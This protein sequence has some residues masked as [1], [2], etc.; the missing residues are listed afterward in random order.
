MHPAGT[1]RVAR[2][3][4]METGAMLFENAEGSGAAAVNSAGPNA[5]LCMPDREKS[6][7]A[8]CPPIRP[9]GYEHVQHKHIVRKILLENTAQFASRKGTAGAIAGFSCWALGYLDRRYR[10]VGCLLHPARHQG[11]DERNRTGFGEKCRRETCPEAGAFLEL[12]PVVQQKWL[13]LAAGLDAFSYSSRKMNPMWTLLGWGSGLLELIAQHEPDTAFSAGKFFKDY[14]FFTTGLNSR[15]HAYLVLSL[16]LRESPDLL[17][18]PR[19]Q[20]RFRTFSSR[21]ARSLRVTSS[22]ASEAPFTHR[23]GLDPLFLDFA[24]LS[25][26]ITRMTQDNALRLKRVVDAALLNF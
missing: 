21:L 8:C 5:T 24:R 15:A 6:C 26:G 7:F 1:G 22:P 13:G 2:I 25:A 10:Q 3:K 20:K 19:F 23:L 4:A 18:D 17:K 12:S 11:S 9:A 16:V 14:P